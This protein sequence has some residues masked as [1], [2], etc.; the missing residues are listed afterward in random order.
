MRKSRL[1]VVGE[2]EA[3]LGELALLA[4]RQAHEKL[5]GAA[6]LFC[7]RYQINIP[8]SEIVAEIISVFTPFVLWSL[9]RVDINEIKEPDFKEMIY[10]G[11]RKI[12]NECTSILDKDGKP[13]DA[14][15]KRR[16]ANWISGKTRE[17]R[18]RPSIY[19]DEVI[20]AVVKVIE[21]L[22]NR[23]FSYSH[24]RYTSKKIGQSGSE[25]GAPTGE[26]LDLLIAT[27]DW[28]WRAAELAGYPSRRTAT[29]EG[30]LNALG[31]IQRQEKT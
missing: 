1:L 7:T 30:V 2:R 12:L 18:G 15:D 27:I 11:S 25:T 21:R 26:M 28:S 19:A 9:S 16:I 3:T 13:L 23:P 5:F 24:P 22:A 20:E 8:T 4:E 10:S 17:E 14:R 31:R 29:K 6:E